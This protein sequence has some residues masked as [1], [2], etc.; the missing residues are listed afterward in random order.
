MPKEKINTY[1]TGQG[2]LQFGDRVSCSARGRTRR[3]AEVRVLKKQNTQNSNP[4]PRAIH[5]LLMVNDFSLNY[6]TRN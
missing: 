3:Q 2:I 4:G 6:D 5:L 1:I